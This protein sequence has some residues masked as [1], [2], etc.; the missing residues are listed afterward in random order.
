MKK[1]EFTIE[2]V[3]R[4]T[5]EDN[6]LIDTFVNRLKRV[7][8]DVEICLNVPWVYIDKIN[9]KRVTETFEG[10]HG[11]TV[12]FFPVSLKY[13]ACFTDITEIFNLIRKYI[14]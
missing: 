12:A 6:E 4:R 9:G 1:S 10:D 11:F 8:V 14:K 2:D 7:G 5:K 13:K 3:N